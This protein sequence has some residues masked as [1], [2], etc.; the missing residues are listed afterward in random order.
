M[1]SATQLLHTYCGA[2]AGRDCG[3]LPAGSLCRVCG[4]AA[5]RGIEAQRWE[6]TWLMQAKIRAEHSTVACEACVY[7]TARF[8]PVP[9]KPP[10]EGKAE[11]PRFSNLSHLYEE[12][13]GRVWYRAASKG[14]KPAIRAFLARPKA[15]L[16]FAAIADSGQKHVLPWTPVNAPGSRGAR[17]L[18][19]ESAVTIGPAG[20]VDAMTALLTAGATKEDIGRG[21]YGAFAWQRCAQD[22]ERFEA[23]HGSW[24]ASA[25]WALAL[26][27]AQRDEVAVQARMDAEKA[28]RA[29]AKGRH[30]SERRGARATARGDDAGGGRRAAR[31]PAHAGGIGAEALGPDTGPREDGRAHER[32]RGGVG[33]GT[34]AEPAPAGPRQVPL[35]FG[36]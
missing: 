6:P 29:A 11:G 1:I 36:A 33:D 7:L 16:W 24:R 26:W 14:E 13:D 17:V 23:A 5:A 31:V 35:D 18:F 15:G 12:R 25:W 4:A 9:G 22:I 20:L 19:E 21:E 10:A 28:A 8:S 30:G 27:L 34:V 32:E 3:P 2:P